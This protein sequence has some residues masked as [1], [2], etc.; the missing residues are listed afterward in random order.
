MLVY[1]TKLWSRLCQKAIFLIFVQKCKISSKII[2]YKLADNTEEK[3]HQ[4]KE[5]QLQ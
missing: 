5:L 1:F 2:N 3:W 4:K